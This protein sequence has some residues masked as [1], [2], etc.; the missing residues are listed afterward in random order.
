[1]G[2][3]EQA[4]VRGAIAIDDDLQ[5][6]GSVEREARQ[7]LPARMLKSASSCGRRP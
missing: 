2:I 6:V 3:S 5:L 7:Q 4:G 1:M